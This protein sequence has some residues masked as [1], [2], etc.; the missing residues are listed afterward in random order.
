MTVSKST[1]TI[2]VSRRIDGTPWP[3]RF[4]SLRG[5]ADGPGTAFVSGVYGDK[6]MGVLACNAWSASSRPVPDLAGEVIIAAAVNLPALEIATRVSP[7]HFYLNRRYPGR[8]TGLPHRRSATADAVVGQLRDRVDV[9]VDL[10]SG[11]PTMGLWYSYTDPAEV[12]LSSSFGY[13]PLCPAPG[14]AGTLT[15]A[16]KGLGIRSFIPEFGG[17]VR[18]DI[19]PGV[20]GCLNVLRY[21][22]QLNDAPTGPDRIRCSASDRSSWSRSMA[23]SSASTTPPMWARRSPPASSGAS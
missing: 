7:D 11:T 3:I 12:E 13:L 21:R 20:E 5:S 4:V 16:V 10:H 2:P 14:Y 8:A 9:A 1:W 18:N 17:G 15:N 6:A 23:C 19:T 22:G